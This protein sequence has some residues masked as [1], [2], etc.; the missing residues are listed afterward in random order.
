MTTLTQ[1]IQEVKSTG[2]AK[3]S[4]FLVSMIKPPVIVQAFDN[5]KVEKICL[6]CDQSQLPGISV[7]SS[8]NRT[9]GELRETPYEMIYEPVN[10]SFYVDSN[11]IV[12]SYFDAWIAGMQDKETRQWS[13]YKDYIADI[14]IIVYN[15]ENNEVYD[16][17]LYEAYPKNVGAIQLDYA[18][19]DVMKVQV[20]LNYKYWKATRSQ[21][22][23][24]G[25]GSDVFQQ[26]Q[27]YDMDAFLQQGGLAALASNNFNIPASYFSDF[28]EFNAITSN[29][30]DQYGQVKEEVAAVSSLM[31]RFA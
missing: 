9:F 17:T 11:L 15:E 29:Y 4:K 2:F 19:K 24:L 18:A 28:N 14:R 12:K 5:S 26:Y 27:D 21:A 20:T 16:V 7:G 6:F 30:M 8:P 25:Q 13:Y 23:N 1:F 31:N 3:S 22:M 10:L